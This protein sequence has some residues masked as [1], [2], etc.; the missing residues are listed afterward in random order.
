MPGEKIAHWSV[1]IQIKLDSFL[2]DDGKLPPIFSYIQ[3][4][5]L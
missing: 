3:L 2:I 1:H 4:I 5:N